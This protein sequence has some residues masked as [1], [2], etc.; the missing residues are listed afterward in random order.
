MGADYILSAKG[1]LHFADA[2]IFNDYLHHFSSKSLPKT[3]QFSSFSQK[4][5]LKDVNEFGTLGRLFSQ[6]GLLAVGEELF[7][8]EGNKIFKKALNA[9]DKDFVLVKDLVNLG[10]INAMGGLPVCA[11][12]VQGKK[13]A[14]ANFQNTHLGKALAEIEIFLSQNG[15]EFDQLTA[16]IQSHQAELMQLQNSGTA[17]EKKSAEWLLALPNTRNTLKELK[18]INEKV[19]EF[20]NSLRYFD[21]VVENKYPELVLKNTK[22]IRLVDPITLTAIIGGVTGIA[23]LIWGEKPQPSG[24]SGEDVLALINSINAANLANNQ[25][26]ITHTNNLVSMFNQTILQAMENMQ[27]TT[28]QLFNL[29]NNL[30][31]TTSLSPSGNNT[32]NNLVKGGSKSALILATIAKSNLAGSK[33]AELAKRFGDAM[34]TLQLEDWV[35]KSFDHDLVV[36]EHSNAYD[37]YHFYFT[38]VPYIFGED[39]FKISFTPYIFRIKESDYS[40]YQLLSA[41]SFEKF[42]PSFDMRYQNVLGHS[43]ALSAQQVQTAKNPYLYPESSINLH[44]GSCVSYFKINTEIFS[45]KITENRVG[46]VKYERVIVE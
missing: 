41:N 46:A 43:F 24:L 10:E 28:N 42:V 22:N 25:A 13:R 18:Q 32:M 30:L 7:K 20:P 44:R 8:L 4:H 19:L 31:N 6:E 9:E 16:E 26:W 2:E 21:A 45:S 27:N 12:A 1:Y 14:K 3:A 39:I 36:F 5:L 40:K 15:A 35:E 38:K 37:Y 23:N 34:E 33:S 11:G 17:E 29:L